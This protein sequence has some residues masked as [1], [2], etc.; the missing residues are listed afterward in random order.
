MSTS[1]PMKCCPPPGQSHSSPQDMDITGTSLAL[2]S[3]PARF[4]VLHK[5]TYSWLHPY[6]CRT[7]SVHNNSTL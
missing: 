5:A 4:C 7:H 1:C 2:P 3:Y 6:L